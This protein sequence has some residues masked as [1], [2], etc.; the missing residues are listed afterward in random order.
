MNMKPFLLATALAVSSAHAQTTSELEEVIVTANRTPQ[1]TNQTGKTVTV[2]PRSEL[3]ASKGRTLSQVLQEQAGIVI[4]G[5]LNNLGSVQTVYVRGANSGRVLILIDGVPTGDPSYLDNGF[6][7]NFLSTLDVERIEIAR[8]NQSTLYGSDAIAGV[9]NIITRRGKSTKPIQTKASF[10]GGQ[11]GTF[12]GDLQAVGQTG[13]WSYQAGVSSL[14]SNGFSSSIDTTKTGN[15][16]NDGYDGRSANASLRFQATHQLMLHAFTRYSRYKSDVDGGAFRDDA[17]FTIDNRMH[18]TGAGFQF[19][20]EHVTL[21][22]NYQYTE[23]NRNFLNDSGSISGFSTFET[24]RYASKGQFAELYA[25]VKLSKTLTLLQ[26]ADYRFGRYNSRYLSISAFGPYEATFTDTSVSQSSLYASLLYAS[27]NE[28]LHLELGGRLNVHSRYG[29]NYTYT[30][31]PSYAV[32]KHLRFFGSVATGFKAPGLYQLYSDFGALSLKPEQSI[33]YEAGIEYR[34]KAIRQRA[35]F[36]YREVEDG[37]D[38]D[39]TNYV[40]FNNPRQLVRGLEYEASA[41]IQRWTIQGNY[42]YLSG[43]DFNQ[44]RIT[45]QDTAYR[46]LLRR[47]AHTLQLSVRYAGKNDQWQ[48]GMSARYVSNRRDLGGYQQADVLLDSY[49][50][51]NANASYR[52]KPYLPVF[53]QLLNLTNTRFFDLRGYNG[54]PFNL[55]AGFTLEW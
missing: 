45:F 35:V 28:Q 2:I 18:I 26:G 46:Y 6:D 32:N 50:L 36:F 9:I 34:K 24:D 48:A 53:V 11:F 25:T 3:E 7:L 41:S 1:K 23:N 8:G 55:Q 37:I 27:K 15:F 52:I 16:D 54:M 39:Y 14:R 40:Y 20:Q 12:R 19:N 5:S 13:R 33:S 29:S 21:T 49:I 22:G 47:P 17:D 31:N 51:F 4:N 43:T 44:S 30:F 42:T 38:F 10:S